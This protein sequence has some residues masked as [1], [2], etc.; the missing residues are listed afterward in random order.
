MIK[1]IN[2]HPFITAIVCLWATAVLGYFTTAYNQSLFPFTI[3]AGITTVG[4]GVKGLG[5]A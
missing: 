2:E 5:E 3:A 4:F 1:Y